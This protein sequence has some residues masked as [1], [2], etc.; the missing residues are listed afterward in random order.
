[1]DFPT[2]LNLSAMG[3]SKIILVSGLC[4]ML[5]FYAYVIQKATESIVASGTDRR[6]VTQARL[7]SS[8]ALNVSCN[9]LSG[10][11]WKENLVRNNKEISGGAM[12]WLI[13]TTRY[14][15]GEV[16]VMTK[17]VF[18]KDTVVQYAKLLK[19]VTVGGKK[20]WNRWGLG[21]IFARPQQMHE[22]EYRAN[23]RY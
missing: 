10:S 18:G 4:V 17:G 19:G 21:S 20:R 14:S 9:Y 23:M 3:S 8:A 12:S 2:T 11:S 6:A 5:G 22:E 15:L 16:S 13:D 7:I 1:V